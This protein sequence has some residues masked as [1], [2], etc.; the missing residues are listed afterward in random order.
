M[1]EQCMIDSLK[2]TDMSLLK[3][4]MI[5]KKLISNNYV[6]LFLFVIV[7]G[8]A[9]LVLYYFGNNMYKTLRDYRKNNKKFEL[10][11]SPSDNQYDVTA[12]NEV[13]QN[14]ADTTEKKYGIYRV[15][16]NSNSEDY[17]RQNK[18]DFLDDIKNRYDEYN[19][20]KSDYILT[21]YNKTNDDIIDQNTLYEKHDNYS[22]KKKEY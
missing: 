4:T 17:I 15:D 22:Y 9:S 11:P 10:G 5:L 7:I 16:P 21:T 12:D 3:N 20:L 1:D 18:R 2:K 8:V 19:T 6:V 13:Y 14:I